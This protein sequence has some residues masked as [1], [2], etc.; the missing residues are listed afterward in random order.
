L[1]LMLPLAKQKLS[2]GPSSWLTLIYVWEL[3]F[4][5]LDPGFF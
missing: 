2:G 1:A 3:L 4:Y 5:V